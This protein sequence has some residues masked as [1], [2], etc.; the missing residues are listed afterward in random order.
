[1]F[2]KMFPGLRK[3]ATLAFI[4]EMLTKSL[5]KLPC[6]SL[7]NLMEKCCGKMLHNAES[8]ENCLFHT[9]YA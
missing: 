4:R 5:E 3:D 6:K 9:T 1:M 8:L 2:G 7:Q